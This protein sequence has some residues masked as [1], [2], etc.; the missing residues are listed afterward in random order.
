MTVVTVAAG[1]SSSQDIFL[2]AND[3]FVLAYTCLP[4][5]PHA[6][7]GGLPARASLPQFIAVRAF[8]MRNDVGP[9]PADLAAARTVSPL[10]FCGTAAAW[11][12]WLTELDASG[13]LTSAPFVRLRDSDAVLMTLMI[14]N[15]AALHILAADHGLSEPF[16]TPAVPAGRGRGRGRGRGAVIPGV[17]AVAGP[18][19]LAFINVATLGLFSNLSAGNSAPLL[20]FCRLVGALG[21]C[22]TRA[23]R[24]DLM[25]TVR[26]AATVLRNMVAK[27]AGLVPPLAPGV[28]TDAILAQCLHPSI[29]DAFQSMS[30]ILALDVASESGLKREMHD[31]FV[32]LYGT[33]TEREGV[34]TRRLHLVEDK[35]AL[36]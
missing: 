19:E 29:L 25:S 4:W 13:L 35:H 31:A 5:T 23:V 32:F 6:A 1:I 28:A 2:A 17:A 7:A 15:G 27:S 16:D 18:A 14:Q 20:S 9:A 24:L 36:S 3:P 33:E 11:S 34:V 22:L 21:P 8:L 10:T 12:R 26:T 30:A